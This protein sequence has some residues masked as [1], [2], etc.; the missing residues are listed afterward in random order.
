MIAKLLEKALDFLLGSSRPSPEPPRPK[1]APT[2]EPPPDPKRVAAEMRAMAAWLHRQADRI[3]PLV[4]P[5]FG[6]P[7]AGILPPSWNTVLDD[8]GESGGIVRRRHDPA[9]QDVAP[10][11]VLPSPVDEEDNDPANIRPNPD[12]SGQHPCGQ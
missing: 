4:I 8:S 9:P 6:M 12:G 2:P 7:P 3:D 11:I 1:P 5:S 10:A